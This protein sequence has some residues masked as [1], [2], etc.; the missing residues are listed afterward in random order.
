MDTTSF[1]TKIV[2]AKDIKRKWYIVDAEDQVLGRMSSQIVKILQGKHKASYAP[3]IDMGDHVIVINSEKFKLTGN[4]MESKK[5]ISYSG[6]PG[7]QKVKSVKQILSKKPEFAIEKAVKGMLPKT[8]LGNAMFKKLHVFA[9][10]DHDHEA[11]TPETL[12]IK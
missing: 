2:S 10:P 11:Q 6:Y 8:K 7:G 5:Y 3:N 12:N 1:K 9:G 4:K